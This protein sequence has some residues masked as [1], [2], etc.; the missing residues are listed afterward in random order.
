MA[1]LD[2]PELP[3]GLTLTGYSDAVAIGPTEK[4]N[5]FTVDLKRDWC[6]GIGIYLLTFFSPLLQTIHV[7]S[8][9]KPIIFVLSYQFFERLLTFSVSVPQGG[10]LMSILCRATQVYF[11]THQQK[12]NQPDL[13]T[14]HV[15]YLARSVVGPATITIIP[16]KLG[17][18]YSTV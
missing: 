16:L 13:I 14:S 10:Y 12:L 2:V 4:P 17:R 8:L 3:G 7:L 18:Q 1:T 6:I 5:V 11:Q 9:C 15:T